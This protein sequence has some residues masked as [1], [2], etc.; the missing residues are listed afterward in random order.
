MERLRATVFQLAF[1]AGIATTGCVSVSSL[2]RAET[3]GK[4]H[5][6]FGFEPAMWL[7][8]QAVPVSTALSAGA[9]KINT[10][11]GPAGGMSVRYGFSDI[12]DF[13]MRVS[14]AGVEVAT[15]IQIPNPDGLVILSLNPSV[16]GFPAFDR[17]RAPVPFSATGGFVS[18]QLP[19]LVGVPMGEHEFVI[20]PKLVDYLALAGNKPLGVPL[21]SANVLCGG[22]TLS[23]A[24]KLAPGVQLIP[25]ISIVH[26]FSSGS[27]SSAVTP[28]TTATFGDATSNALQAGPVVVQLS[29]GFVLGE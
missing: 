14:Q 27:A 21:D 5:F 19:L 11:L 8:A 1:L 20:G 7:S 24:A 10:Q 2:Q 16:S 4:Y 12:V 28:L 3:L 29:L 17:S 23:F 18:V 26:A 22:V 13:G 9:E 25:E 15:K 6:Q